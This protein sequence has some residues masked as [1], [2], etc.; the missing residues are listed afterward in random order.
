MLQR[1]AVLVSEFLRPADHPRARVGG[2]NI[3]AETG[4]PDRKLASS[5]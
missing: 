4:E 1:N 3:Q 2:D 5:T